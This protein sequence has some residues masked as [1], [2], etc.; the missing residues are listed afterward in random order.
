MSAEQNAEYPVHVF[1]ENDKGRRLIGMHSRA[2]PSQL[3]AVLQL[4]DELGA[5]PG[6]V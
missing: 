4:A 1:E 2:C 6:H 3:I 5:G